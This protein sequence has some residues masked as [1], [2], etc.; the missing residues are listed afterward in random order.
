MEKIWLQSYQPGVPSTI[1]PDRYASL[2]AFFEESCAAFKDKPAFINLGHTLHYKDVEVQSR[3]FAAYLQND[4]QLQKG[5]RVG[6]MMP[7]LLQYPVVLFGILRAGCVVVNINP[8]CAP[9]ELEHTLSD[10]GAQTLV[11]LDQERET[12]RVVLKNREIKNI[13][14]TSVGDLLPWSTGLMINQYLKLNLKLKKTRKDPKSF[15]QSE[16]P[17]NNEISL[18]KVLRIG[19][20]KTFEKPFISGNDLAFLQYTG[21]TTGL[22]KGAMLSHRNMVANIEQ[23]VAW[24]TSIASK[25]HRVITALPLYHI[26]SLTANC[27]TFFRMGAVNILVTDPRQTKALIKI[28]HHYAFTAMT[29]VNTLFKSLLDHP[30]FSTVDFSKKPLVLSGGMALQ[31][32]VAQHWETVTGIPLV[33]GYGLTEA[34]P[35]VC[36]N[37]I[38]LLHYQGS[39]GLPVS[40]TTISIRDPEGRELAC[41]QAGELWV[42]GPQVML[43]YWQH[44]QETQAVFED[45][46]LK[47]GDIA[48]IDEQGFVYILDRKKDMM[49]ISGFNVYP[50]EVEAVIASMEGVFEVAVCGIK[51]EGLE[52]VKAFVVK[53]DP[54]LSEKAILAYCHA[55]LSAYKVPKIIEFR[56]HLPKSTVGK[57]LRRLLQ[58]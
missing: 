3:A 1:N 4:L 12:V 20:K 18:K 7:N 40:S 47:T 26:F 17:F 58:T 37:P 8:L 6:M 42:Q 11:I 57:V 27:L 43:G 46:Y 56:D 31:P 34:S 50:N 23:A 24:L 25:N 5:D 29:G 14:V 55:Q 36:I 48:R 35:A 28:M 2:N 32:E 22:S 13:I 44:P 49:I 45:G 53:R 52:I 9:P 41:N 19:S 21:G 54:K 16:K 33:E 10:S 15:F 30:D 39:I 38:N 51:I